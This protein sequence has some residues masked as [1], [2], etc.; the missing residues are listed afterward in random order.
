MDRIE[1]VKN[2]MTDHIENV[3]SQMI[4][5]IENVKSQMNERIENVKKF[6]SELIEI[7]TTTVRTITIIFC[8]VVLNLILSCIILFLFA[9]R[10][11]L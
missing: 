9:K 4:H 8:L 6:K 5:R 3:R 11:T 1:N 2:Q 7:K 10:R